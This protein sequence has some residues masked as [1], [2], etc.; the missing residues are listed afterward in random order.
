M[1]DYYSKLTLLINTIKNSAESY[2]TRLNQLLDKNRSTT[3]AIRADFYGT[4][5]AGDIDT[6][7]RNLTGTVQREKETALSTRIVN[8]LIKYVNQNLA[9]NATFLSYPIPTL[10]ALMMDFEKYL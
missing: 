3:R 5:A 1:K 2:E 6:L 7:M 4:R 8:L 9:I 10:I